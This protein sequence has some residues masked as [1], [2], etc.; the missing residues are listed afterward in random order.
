MTCKLKKINKKMMYH[1]AVD[2]GIKVGNFRDCEFQPMPKNAGF[3]VSNEYKLFLDTCMG[4]VYVYV[5]NYDGSEDYI[6][7]PDFSYLLEHGYLDIIP[8]PEDLDD[9]ENLDDPEVSEEPEDPEVSENLAD[10]EVS[11]D[12]VQ[13]E[14]LSLELYEQYDRV[15]ILGGSFDF[16]FAPFEVKDVTLLNHLLLLSKNSPGAYIKAFDS[17][18]RYASNFS[19]VDEFYEDKTAW[20]YIHTMQSLRGAYESED[21][22]F[23]IKLLRL[24]M[25]LHEP[26]SLSHLMRCK[27]GF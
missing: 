15:L 14:V 19:S 12:I 18:A 13:S 10:P 5:R 3:L 27:Y 25:W 20:D 6:L 7:K 26:F 21:F 2:H 16:P 22:V 9:S 4:V 23:D 17:Y 8:D 1:I 24:W 11:K